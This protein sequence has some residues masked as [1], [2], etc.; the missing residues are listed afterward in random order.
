LNQLTQGKTVILLPVFN[1][2]KALQNLL[3][4]LKRSL[5]EYGLT[6]FEVLIINDGSVDEKP[7]ELYIDVKT[8]I[9]N[10]THNLGHQKAI[11]VGLSYVYHNLSCD[12]VLV[13]DADG[14]DRPEDAVTLLEYSSK[15]RDQIVVGGRTSRKEGITRQFFYALYIIIFRF[16]TGKSIRFGNFSLIP[17]KHIYRLI[18]KG[19]IW[20]HLPGGIIKSK[21]SYCIVPTKKGTRYTG[22]SKMSFTSLVFHGIGALA[23]FIDIIAIRLLIASCLAIGASLLG[24]AA[25]FIIKITTSLAIPGW[26]SILGSSIV[27]II[28]V[29]F[30]IGLF[31]IFSFLMSQSYRRFIPAIHYKEFIENIESLNR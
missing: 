20:L 29:S 25:I 26:A 19:D 31:L 11:A 6:D 2:W 3:K 28:L 21:L 22:T 17:F 8:T 1:D 16:L 24:L 14:D 30:L 5:N 12:C 4:E 27:I 15:K 13:M 9:V 10:L 18:S 23:V 7:Y